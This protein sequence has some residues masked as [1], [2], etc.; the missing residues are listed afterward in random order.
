M[1]LAGRPV[2]HLGPCTH[3]SGAARVVDRAGFAIVAGAG[4]LCVLA[5]PVLA[6]LRLMALTGRRVAD[7]RGPGTSTGPV[8]GVPGGARVAIA[9]RGPHWAQGVLA[10]ASGRGG[11]AGRHSE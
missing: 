1:A 9:A 8:T 7:L 5:F 3:R 4:T 10:H 6:T 2:T 11:R